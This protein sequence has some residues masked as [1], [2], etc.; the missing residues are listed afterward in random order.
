MTR[1]AF[2]PGRN[3]AMKLLERLFDRDLAAAWAAYA[4]RITAGWVMIL[5]NLSTVVEKSEGERL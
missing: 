4:E 3:V 1:P 5:D 2:R